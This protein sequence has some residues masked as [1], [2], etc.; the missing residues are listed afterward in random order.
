MCFCCVRFSFFPYQAKRLAWGNVLNDL[1][2]VASGTLYHN[3]VN[4]WCCC[5]ER[6]SGVG[7]FRRQVGR[8]TGCSS[9]VACSSWPKIP[10]DCQWLWVAPTWPTLST[11]WGPA[12]PIDSAYRS[13][14][15]RSVGCFSTEL[16]ILQSELRRRK[17][18]PALA[19]THYCC[20]D[21]TIGLVAQCELGDVIIFSPP[22][23]WWTNFS[24]GH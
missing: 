14:S 5:A 19:T 3:S 4:R 8:I 7:Q 9:C 13:S 24:P 16:Y 22:E 11:V 20:P 21:D 12:S 17:L 2:C 15:L 18:S 10:A 6:M 1:L 23:V